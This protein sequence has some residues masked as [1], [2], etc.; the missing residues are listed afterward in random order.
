PALRD[1]LEDLPALIRHFVRKFSHGAAESGQAPISPEAMRR[2][3]SFPFARGNVRELERVVQEAALL[4]AGGT[5]GSE[6]LRL[7]RPEHPL[8][9]PRVGLVLGGGVVRGTAHVGVIRAFE[10][11][12]IP[13]DCLVGTSSGSLVGALYAGGLDWRE[14]AEIA[15]NLS[16]FDMAEPVWPRGGF[17]TNRRMRRFLDSHIGPVTFDK[18][19]IPFAAV[20]ADANTGQEVVL[21]EGRVA[22]AVR[23]STAIPGLFRPVEVGGRLLVDGVVVNNVPAGVA[24]AMGADLVVAVDV[25]E[26]G[27]SAGAP[28]SVAEAVMRA[29]DIMTRQTI[30]TSLEWADVVI[31]P[32]ISGL[33]SFSPRS[34]GEYMR[35]GYA[36]AREQVTEIRLRL[37]ELRRE[38]RI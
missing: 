30:T 1:R 20:A 13:I 4:A 6:H 33:N 8:G 19:R 38:M 27:F 2:L 7:N 35:R 18:L 21:K 14:L 11:E 5:I 3:A 16:W 31:R 32:Q 29:F 26:Y 9:R 23:G 37:E 28:R 34:A 15:R 25:T 12:G 17:V 24:R 10:E 22:D 36:A